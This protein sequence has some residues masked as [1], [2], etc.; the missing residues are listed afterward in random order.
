MHPS[1]WT[2]ALAIECREDDQELID[3]LAKLSDDDTW[4]AVEAERAFL[5]AMDGGCQV[6]IAG[7]AT[8]NGDEITMTGLIAAPDASVVY[9]EVL[10]G[11]RCRCTWKRTSP[12][13]NGTR[14]I[15]FNPTSE[16]RFECL[17]KLL[18]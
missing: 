16:G 1:S 6:P 7:H 13:C 15:R 10:T 14:S 4:V 12:Y 3:E 8:I 9:K 18:C 2:R 17:I 11:N 5:A